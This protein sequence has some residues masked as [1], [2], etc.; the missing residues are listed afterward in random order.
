V[1]SCLQRRHIVLRRPDADATAQQSENNDPTP[2]YFLSTASARPLPETDKPSSFTNKFVVAAYSTVNEIPE[3]L[4]Q[5][6]CYCYCKRRGHRSLLDCFTTKHAADC[7]ICVREAIVVLQEYKQGKSAEQI[8]TEIMGSKSRLGDCLQPRCHTVTRTFSE[9]AGIAFGMSWL[10]RDGPD[11][12]MCAERPC[13]HG[14][15]PKA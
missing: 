9:L 12:P 1:C 11:G 7:D 10:Q 14:N 6:P 15:S 8:R 13:W 5:Q 3:V 4:V 2:P